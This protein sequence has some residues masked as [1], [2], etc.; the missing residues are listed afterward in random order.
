[1][2]QR[3][4]YSDKT[5]IVI[6]GMTHDQLRPSTHISHARW[7]D[8]LAWGTAVIVYEQHCAGKKVMRFCNVPGYNYNKKLGID[9]CYDPPSTPNRPK[10][11]HA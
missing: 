1:V 3:T 6:S 7:L 9:F 4:Y 10:T 8:G 11:I 2:Q 5:D